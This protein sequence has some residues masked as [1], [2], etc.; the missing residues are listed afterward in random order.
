ME[1]TT[2]ATPFIKDR[3]ILIL[4]I[5]NALVSLLTVIITLFR[6][7]SNDFKVPVQYIV[8]D[9]S[10]LQTSSWYS[11]YS[12]VFF[13]VLSAAGAIF[14]AYKLHKSNR[15]FAGGI[16]AA[17][18]IVGIFTFRVVNSLLILVSKV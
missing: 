15:I 2:E 5:A 16:L 6:L 14:F 9:G 7:R 4:A 13:A 10:V 11:L 8:H 12:L 1:K 3:P 17:Y 18:L